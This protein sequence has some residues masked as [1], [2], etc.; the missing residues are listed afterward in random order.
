MD[1]PAVTPAASDSPR[2]LPDSVT[3]T[4]TLS[5]AIGGG[6]AKDWLG[7]WAKGQKVLVSPGAE[8]W[9]WGEGGRRMGNNEVKAMVARGGGISDGDGMMGFGGREWV[10]VRI[11][12]WM[13]W[14]HEAMV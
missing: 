4:G 3:H 12:C 8:A 7:Y 9:V 13:V 14:F 2:R 10:R 11:K 1:G 6:R 5:G